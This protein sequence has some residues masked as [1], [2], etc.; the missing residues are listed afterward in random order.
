MDSS[1]YVGP[2]FSSG[3]T[4][5]YVGPNFSSGITHG[6]VGPNFSSGI[7]RYPP[8]TGGRNATSSPSLSTASMRAYSALTAP[9]IEPR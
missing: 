8:D 6:Y 4:R 1:W 2:N 9:E 7:T 5:G 3:I